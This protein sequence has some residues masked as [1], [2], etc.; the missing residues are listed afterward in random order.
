MQPPPPRP[1]RKRRIA[2]WLQD[3]RSYQKSV[4]FFIPRA[5]FV[6]LVKEIVDGFSLGNRVT[7]DAVSAIQESTEMYLTQLFE[8]SFL[9]A[10]HGKRV[11]ILSK[12]LHLAL[13]REWN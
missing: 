5:P 12:D 11:T 3:I 1:H 13:R 7:V 4:K 8:D 6:R 2:K 10:V 9:C